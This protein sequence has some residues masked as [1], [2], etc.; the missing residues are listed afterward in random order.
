M[1]AHH[2]RIRRRR[3]AS[4]RGAILIQVAVAMIVLIAFTAFVADY[5]LMWVGRRQAQNA[6]DAGALAGAI[7]LAF[8]SF[9]DRSDTGPAKVAANSF[10]LANYVAGETPVND[11]TTDVTFPACPDDGSNTCIRVD[12]YR[13]LAHGN[14]LPIWFGQLVGLTEQG[15]RATAMAQ[16]A[17]GNASDCLK[18]FGIPDK[19]DDIHDEDAPIDANNWTLDDHFERLVKDTPKGGNDETPLPDPDVY[20]APTETE[21]GTGFNLKEDLG[22]LLVLK[23][24]GPQEALAPGFFFPIRL[25]LPNGEVSTGGDDYRENIAR[26]NGVPVKIGDAIENEPGNMQGPTAQGM[27]DLYDLDPDATFN[28]STNEIENSCAQSENPCAPFSPRLVAVPVFDTGVYYDGKL[29]GLVTLRIANILGFF[30]NE[31]QGG[32]VSGYFM[33]MPGLTVGGGV[34]LNPESAFLT[35]ITLVR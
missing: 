19:W 20:V 3:S 8:D 28:T 15:V 10:A 24:G 17:T 6:A 34:T 5:G 22:R 2:Y 27:Q 35:S 4:E 14:P 32:E 1:A 30:I 23:S 33:R 9:S 18:P 26:C 25:P 16:A 21:V 7:A 13:N 12:V 31:I 29:N 11:I